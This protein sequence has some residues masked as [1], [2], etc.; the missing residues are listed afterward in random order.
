[1]VGVLN[2]VLLT[3]ELGFW[4][5]SGRTGGFVSSGSSAIMGGS[6][7]GWGN[8]DSI[9]SMGGGGEPPSNVSLKNITFVTNCVQYRK[10][11]SKSKMTKMHC[12]ELRTA[13][14]EMM[15]IA[16]N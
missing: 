7:P 3:A 9:V 1:M 6:V 10:E 2:G 4:N 11:F 5:I 8:M 15:S 14:K 13:L 12:L 16:F